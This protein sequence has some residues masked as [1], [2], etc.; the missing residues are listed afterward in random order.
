M[1]EIQLRALKVL[2]SW[3]RAY[4]GSKVPALDL[5]YRG[6]THA[7]LKALHRRGFVLF[8]QGQ[9]WLSQWMDE[10]WKFHL[11]RMPGRW[12]AIITPEGIAALN[13]VPVSVETKPTETDLESE[14]DPGHC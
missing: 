2:A 8:E 9:P 7:T 14:A 10:R 11:K 12:R 5:S 13:R 3:E 6:I 1:N 4:P